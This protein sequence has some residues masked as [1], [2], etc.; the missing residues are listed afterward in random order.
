[1][2]WSAIQE[3][4]ED[5]SNANGPRLSI[6]M[7]EQLERLCIAED[8]GARIGASESRGSVD[9]NLETVRVDDWLKWLVEA[10]NDSKHNA[11]ML[12][13]AL[14]DRFEAGL[15]GIQGQGKG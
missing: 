12:F 6:G 3:P 7:V 2:K 14:Y 8:G 15:Q 4:D 13:E 10:Y 1:M 5:D 11:L 9:E